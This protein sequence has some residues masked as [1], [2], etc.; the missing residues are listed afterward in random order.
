MLHICYQNFFG[1]REG[2]SSHDSLP[3]SPSIFP[4]LAFID[5]I[6]DYHIVQLACLVETLGSSFCFLSFGATKDP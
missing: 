6:S 2:K 5:T 3:T 1:E 4:F